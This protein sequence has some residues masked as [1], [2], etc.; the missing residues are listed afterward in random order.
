MSKTHLLSSLFPAVVIA[1]L[2]GC[3]ADTPEGVLPFEKSVD[4]G[5]TEDPVDAF[6]DGE[7]LVM[8][9]NVWTGTDECR[10]A[11][12][13]AVGENVV[14]T[15]V[16]F[17]FKAVRNLLL[18]NG[19]SIL[20]GHTSETAFGQSDGMI[21]RLN[22]LGVAQ[23]QQIF[24]GAGFDVINSVALMPDGGLVA[25]GRTESNT[26]GADDLWALM[27]DVLG[28]IKWEKR[29]GGSGRDGGSDVLVRPDGQIVVFGFTES[30]GAMGRD[31]WLME[32][33]PA[34]GSMVWNTRYGGADYE[35]SH[36]MLQLADGTIVL[37][38]HTASTD[39]THQLYALRV[40]ADGTLIWQREFGTTSAHEGGEHLYTDSKGRLVFLGRTNSFG[41]DE[42]I[43]LVITDQEGNLME[44][45]HFG[46]PGNQQGRAFVEVEGA[47]YIIGSSVYAGSLDT[48]L[49][50]R[51]L[52]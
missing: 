42:D 16:A 1:L 30:D 52:D 23:S 39:A 37:C 41:D 3:E 34:D 10:F 20:V 11:T 29:Y 4:T 13:D 12:C 47:Y 46:G 24:G 40:S 19:Q 25:T 26:A 28:N 14:P 38:G 51:N 7:R 9:T 6:F 49:V 22:T 33:N 31:F 45:N 17:N 2:T 50:R 48:Y 43:Y 8:V 5:M 27:V 32:L 44:E 18:T 35:E 15:S 36:E 21:L